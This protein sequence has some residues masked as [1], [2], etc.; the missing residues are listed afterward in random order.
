MDLNS[1]VGVQEHTLSCQAF[2]KQGT[3]L[4][5]ES[6]VTVRAMRFTGSGKAPAF[7]IERGAKI[8]A[9]GTEGRP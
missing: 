5:I 8:M 9:N 3:T 6:G 1:T 7:I 2:F 4:T